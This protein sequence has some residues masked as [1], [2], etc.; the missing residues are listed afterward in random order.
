MT[1]LN[2][3]AV[4]GTITLTVV[5]QGNG[6]YVCQ[7]SSSL[8]DR[9][10]E[11]LHCHGQTPEHA[12]AIALEKLADKYRHQVEENQ[13]LDWHQ[14]EYTASG[15]LIEKTYHVMLHYEN[16][17]TAEC[18]FEAMHDTILGNTVVENATITVI[19]VDEDLP[20]ES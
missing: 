15:D 5:P 7:L 3:D 17:I 11:D 2:S 12:I 9:P 18:P 10:N 16:T 1:N 13:N 20:I 8:T 19:Q 4:T 6:Q 14:V